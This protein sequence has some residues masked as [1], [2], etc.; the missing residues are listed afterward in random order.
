MEEFRKV[1]V[2]QIVYGE[3]GPGRHEW[4]E[5]IL[6]VENIRLHSG[7]QAVQN[8]TNS[9]NRIFRD[10]N[11][12]KRRI[13]NSFRAGGDRMCIEMFVLI[14]GR[15]LCEPSQKPAGICLI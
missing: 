12:V 7:N 10:R 5:H 8:G 2:R 13:A 11:K 3:N 1:L 15:Q 4:R 14:V 6:A 9:Y